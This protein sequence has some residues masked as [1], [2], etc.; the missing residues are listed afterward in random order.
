M[1]LCQCVCMHARRPLGKPLLGFLLRLCAS[2]FLLMTMS[3]SE[4]VGVVVEAGLD[5]MNTFMLADHGHDDAAVGSITVS[6]KDKIPYRRGDVLQ[7]RKMIVQIH[8]A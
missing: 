3:T 6:S 7:C 1:S 4:A 2:G 8:A 5:D